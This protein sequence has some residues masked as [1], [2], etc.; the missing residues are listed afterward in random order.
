MKRFKTPVVRE[1]F[2]VLAMVLLS[3]PAALT[4]TV[5]PT[6][7]FD[8]TQRFHFTVSEAARLVSVELTGMTAALLVGAWMVSRYD[9]RLLS[10]AAIV[11][12]I[13][14]QLATLLLPSFSLLMMARLAAG[15]SAGTAY[16]VAVA[17]LAG[18]RQP[19]RNF[20]FAV[21]GQQ[22]AATAFFTLVAFYSLGVAAGRTMI[23]FVGLLV[24]VAIATPW[25]PPRA[26]AI[27][28]N[29]ARPG[30]TAPRIWSTTAYLGLLG[31]F[32][33]SMSFGTVWPSIAQIALQRGESAGTISAT[34]A[35]VGY[36][37]I[38]AGFAAASASGHFSRGFLTSLGTLGLAAAVTML[39]FP[40]SFPFIVVV[41][42]FTWVFSAPFYFGTMASIDKTG[43]MVVL[44]SAMLPSGFAVG[45]LLGGSLAALPGFGFI[46]GC[47]VALSLAALT[48]MLTVMARIK[49]VAC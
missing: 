47:S 15:A 27:R 32:L 3:T 44:T 14:A 41:I 31:M 19:E 16:A 17:E 11:V 9:R 38:A 8:Y 23:A 46:V 43:G 37:G 7:I 34:F 30:A 6:I 4:G 2:S 12:G 26:K 36:G 22:I 40:I 10:L 5:A 20:G 49:A 29:P 35:V 28:S 42:M 1:A 45:E 13:A 33:L 18:T 24:L 25:L 48:S 21:A 39:S